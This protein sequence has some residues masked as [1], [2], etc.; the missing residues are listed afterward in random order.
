MPI[1]LQPPQPGDLITA[2]F[3]K[4]LVDLL[5]QL[6]ARVSVLEAVV[7]G[8][9]GQLSISQIVPSDVVVGD[10]IQIVGAN[11][12]L[13]SEDVVSFD[14]TT[15][16][17]KFL[18]G[19]N[20]K[21]LILAVPPISFGKLTTKSVPL[22]VS[23]ARGSASNSITVHTTE[24][25]IPTG[26]ITVSPGQVPAD[27]A[28]GSSF[29]MPFNLSILANL[30]ET[31]NLVPSVPSVSPAWT[32]T[33]VTNAN[34]TT[35]LPQPWQIPITKPSTDTAVTATVFVKV[36]IP[37]GTTATPFVRLDVV[38]QRNPTGPSALTGGVTATF[39][40]GQPQQ[41][42]QTVKF[43][44]TSFT[45]TNVTGDTNLVTLPLPTPTTAPIDGV[46]YSI[47]NLKA[48]TKYTLTLSWKDTTNANQ[49]WTAAFGGAPG[50]G[51]W[52]LITKT[53]T[54]VGAGSDSEKVAIVGIAG[55]KANTLLL[56]VRSQTDS[57][58]D[59]GILSQGIAART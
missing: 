33:M 20:D 26:T 59:Y 53:V 57:V 30:S 9:D 45:G 46:T 16:V 3:A 14:G 47:Q 11:F 18:P 24:A 19:S 7:P 32:A 35:E 5:S 27:I 48:N 10:Q 6:D 52:P 38:S 8:S 34:G 13:P 22:V 4:Q 41:P 2:S 28:P 50:I 12:G 37:L 15:S 31:Y 43:V 55:A 56:T 1:T 54:Q 58:N 42:P 29:V 21:L 25:T 36:T 49:G 23:G 44:V 39:D 51:T 17:T 40:F